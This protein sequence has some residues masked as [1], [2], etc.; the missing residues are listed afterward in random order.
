MMDR[1][2][3]GPLSRDPFSQESKLDHR[4]IPNLT[5]GLLPS[6]LSFAIRWKVLK[7]QGGGCGTDS[8]CLF[9]CQSLCGLLDYLGS[10]LS[11]LVSLGSSIFTPF[12]TLALREAAIFDTSS[13]FSIPEVR[14]LRKRGSLG[15]QGV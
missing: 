7:G 10:L 2:L 13:N 6:W 11:L 3:K 14:P 12:P 15:F 8:C 1:S 4:S 5:L 9:Q